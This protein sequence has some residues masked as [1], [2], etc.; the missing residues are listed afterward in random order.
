MQ[1]VTLN[2]LEEMIRLEYRKV[3]PERVYFTMKKMHLR[4]FKAQAVEAMR[5][6]LALHRLGI[7]VTATLI[8]RLREVSESAAMRQLHMLG[9]AKCLTLLRGG[10]SHGEVGRI[11]NRWVVSALFLERYGWEDRPR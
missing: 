8:A 11:P 7:P 10:S 3:P 5:W 2:K 9:D 4:H 1:A 6:S